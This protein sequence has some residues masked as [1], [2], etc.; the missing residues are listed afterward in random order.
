[1]LGFLLRRQSGTEARSLATTE[2]DDMLSRTGVTIEFEGRLHNEAAHQEL[3]HVAWSNAIAEGRPIEPIA[4]GEVTRLR[5]RDENDWNYTGPVKG[6][7]ISLHEDCDPVR[8][9]FDRGLY[10]QEFIKAQFAGVEMHIKVLKLLNAVEPFFHNLKA[11]GEGEWRETR[12]AANLAE[13]FARAQE[14]IDAELRK[15]PSTQVKV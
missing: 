10:V 1:V 9:E 12:D 14:V 11:E 5:V 7:V 3:T 13:P 4:S 6:I 8:L 2:S 15:N